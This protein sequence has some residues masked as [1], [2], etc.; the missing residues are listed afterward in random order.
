MN[1]L[2]IYREE[3]P[4][5]YIELRAVNFS[6]KENNRVIK[7]ISLQLV[8]DDITAIIGPNG[9]G[10][11]TLGKLMA[12]I[13]KPS[14]GSVLIDGIN[15]NKLKLGAVGQKVGYLF[16]N[17]ERQIFAPTV[18]EDITFALRIKDIKEDEIQI[19]VSEIVEILGLRHLLKDFPFTLSQGEKQRLA[20]AG[21]L[22]NEPTYLILDEPTTGLDSERK[23]HLY[24]ILT[25]LHKKGVG[26]A[27]ISH[28]E[29]FIDKLATRFIEVSGGEVVADRRKEARP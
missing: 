20:L 7:N 4:L 10:K 13:L 18:E 25:G 5:N 23:K 26:M 16:Q 14:E 9:G 12:G 22:I 2:E 27:I 17:P 6:Y 19:K 3:S 28:D 1:L 29:E 8:K 24:T 15:S 21:I 11:T